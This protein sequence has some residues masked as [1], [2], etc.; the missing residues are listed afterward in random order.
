MKRGPKPAGTRTANRGDELITSTYKLQKTIK[1]HLQF[2]AVME[3]RDQS[4]IVREALDEYLRNREIDPNE[5]P[6]VITRPPTPGN[7]QTSQL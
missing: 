1:M 4:D 5:P 3:G 6:Q 2:M 7:N